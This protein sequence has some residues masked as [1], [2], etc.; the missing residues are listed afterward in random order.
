MGHVT[1]MIDRKV[2]CMLVEAAFQA[3]VFL[4]SKK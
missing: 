2:G 3:V 4:S 1:N